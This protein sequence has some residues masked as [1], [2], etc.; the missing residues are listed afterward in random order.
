[1]LTDFSVAFYNLENLFD[2]ENNEFTLDKDY[3]SA[4]TLD[5]NRGRYSRKIENLSKVISKVGEKKSKF[6]PILLGVSEVENETCL[7]DLI[8]SK[9][10]VPYSY[11]FVHYNSPDERGIDVAFLYQK[12][13]FELVYSKTYTLFL[14]D[15]QMN[16][17]YTRDI[18]LVSG[19][20][21]QE[22]VYVIINHWPSRTKGI[23]SSDAKRVKAAI[24]VREIIQEI[25]ME[26]ENAK[27][28]IMGDFND[29]PNCNSIQNFLMGEDLFNPMS[30][31]KQK[32]KGSVKYKGKWYMFD[33]IILSNSF[34]SN[35]LKMMSFKS[36]DVFDAY[37]LQE[38]SGKRKGAPKRTYVGKWHLGG[39]SDH[40]PVY[41][42]FYKLI[43]I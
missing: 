36:A 8:N 7:F 35:S 40:F 25:Q 33:Q 2:I 16:R 29:E 15:E 23:S 17:E 20:L 18:L 43:K 21:F 22:Q 37:F 28:M 24:L 5:W 6:P 11:G 19:K 9:K 10:L 13:H 27:I 26:N 39:Y 34:L 12:K 4:S 3:T 1:M 41:V 31:L 38:K 14:T 30:P 42:T 32:G